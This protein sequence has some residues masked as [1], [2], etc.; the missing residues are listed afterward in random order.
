[1]RCIELSAIAVGSIVQL[2]PDNFF[3]FLVVLRALCAPALLLRNFQTKKDAD[4][5]ILNY[6]IGKGF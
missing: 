4:C 5:C 3:V 6:S 1:M 2:V